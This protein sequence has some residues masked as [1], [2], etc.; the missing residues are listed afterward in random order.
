MMRVGIDAHKKSCTTCVFA[1]GAG[2]GES[3]IDSFVFKTSKAGVSELLARIPEKSV[4]VIESSTTGK[5]ITRLISSSSSSTSSDHHEIH[6]VAPPEKK[7]SVKTDKRDSERIVKEDMLGYLRRCYVPSQYIEDMRFLVTTQIE[8]GAKISRVKNQ[9]HSLIERN[10]VQSEFSELSDVFGVEGLQKLSEIDLPRQ[11]RT[12][13]GMYL[14]ELGLYASQHAQI[15]TE[16]AKLATT[17][18]DCQLLFSHPGISSFT[19]VAIK[20][21]IGDDASRFPSKKH[22]C[23]YAGVVPGADN[24]GERESRHSHVKHGDVILKYALTCAVRG[25]V[26]AKTDSTV[27]RIYLRQIKRGRSAQEAEV[28]AARKLACIIWKILTSKQR[29]VEE[30]KYLTARKAKQASSI[31]ERVVKDAVL[32][33]SVPEL[34]QDLSLYVDVLKAGPEELDRIRNRHNRGTKNIQ[35]A[36]VRPSWSDLK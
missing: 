11:D 14:K 29:Y 22:L 30:D 31:A 36:G 32:P 19:A 17:D 27:K 2:V 34:A 16:I 7:P 5:A 10:M 12:S 18:Q 21:R 33:D 26:R 1:D 6:M 3:P 25:A 20:S 9:V 28:A 15:E 13:L 24:S 23:S 8:I 4:F 35:S